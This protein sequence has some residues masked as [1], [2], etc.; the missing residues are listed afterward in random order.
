MSFLSR[1]ALDALARRYG[2]RCLEGDP[3]HFS[4]RYAEA[5]DREAAAFVAALLS[6]GN[7]KQIS[8]SVQTV[9]GVLGKRP[10]EALLQAKPR[11]WS[12]GLK[13]FRH[14]FTGGADL[15]HVLQILGKILREHRSLERVF[16]KKYRARDM[17]GSLAGFVGAFYARSSERGRLKHLLPSPS[18]GSACKRLNMFMRWM[19]RRDD[20]IDLGLWK[21]V[22]AADLVMPLDTHVARF[23]RLFGL[24]KRKTEDWRM[25]EEITGGL[26]TFCPHDPVRYDFAIAWAG[27]EGAW[28]TR[29]S[30]RRALLNGA[31]GPRRREP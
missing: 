13:S 26:R 21:Q 5:R 24:S 16:L 6:Y 3:A 2:R 25:A 31:G 1:E 11:R 20:G 8:R 12:G 9:L 27:V 10:Y 28:K 17:R 18:N 4:H 19:V 22:R 23:G 15:A 7:V 30:A 14:R 29:A